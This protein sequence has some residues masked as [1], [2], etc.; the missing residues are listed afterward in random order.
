MQQLINK[1]NEDFIITP[2]STH[3]VVIKP[4]ELRQRQLSKEKTN[5]RTKHAVQ[6]KNLDFDITVAELT[7]LA[8][9]FG[10]VKYIDLPMRAGNLNSGTA[11][12]YFAKSPQAQDFS[13]FCHGL[14][15]K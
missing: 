9:D 2:E 1:Y 13:H 5:L 14:D 4:F 12:I 11:T 10:D 15:F 7:R 3:R 8:K 6:V